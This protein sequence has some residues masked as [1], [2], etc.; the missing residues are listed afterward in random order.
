MTTTV[1]KVRI[2]LSELTNTL[3][4]ATKTDKRELT[5]QEIDLIKYKFEQ[6]SP[7]SS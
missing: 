1:E 6:D 5:E 2:V 3:Y 7:A 4:I